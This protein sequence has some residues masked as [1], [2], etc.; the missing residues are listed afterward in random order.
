MASATAAMSAIT[1][2]VA[3]AATIRHG[4]AMPAK[5][6]KASDIRPAVMSAMAVPRNG[7]GMSAA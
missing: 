5:P 3:T 4:L 1:A 7:A 2:I 6:M